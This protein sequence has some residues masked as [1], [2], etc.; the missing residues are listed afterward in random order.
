MTN[1][2]PPDGK[3]FCDVLEKEK[4]NVTAIITRVGNDVDEE[5]SVGKKVSLA[6]LPD[7][8][9]LQG[10]EVYSI[11]SSYVQFIYE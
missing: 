7:M 6:K 10:V 11:H 4:G 8:V 3:I 5:I 9:E 1:L 2:R